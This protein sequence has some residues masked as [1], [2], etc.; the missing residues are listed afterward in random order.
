MIQY[1][2][3]DYIMRVVVGII[4]AICVLRASAQEDVVYD[5]IDEIPESDMNSIPK[6]ETIFTEEKIANVTETT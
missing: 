4:F 6:Q 3:C 2:V 5:E 1:L